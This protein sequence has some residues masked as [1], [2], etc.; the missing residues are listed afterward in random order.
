MILNRSLKE[1]IRLSL[2]PPKSKFDEKGMDEN[3]QNITSDKTT[4]H[5]IIC[6]DPWFSYIR[7]G[8]KPVEGRKNSP[9][10]QKIK[11]GDV[12]DFSNGKDNFQALVIEVKSY[13]SLEDYLS[14][15]A[16]QTALPGVTSMEDAINTYHQWNTPNEIQE[17]G[18]LGIFVKPI[19]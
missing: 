4:K 10:Y 9:K 15:V 3:K 14:D 11:A 7:N 13:A 5:K 2:A 8:L 6:D 12:I 17:W 1:H 16:V 18:F 19:D